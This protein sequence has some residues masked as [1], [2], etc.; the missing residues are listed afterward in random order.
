M[1]FVSSVN[2]FY[3][4]GIAPQDP[5]VS[6]CNNLNIDLTLRNLTETGYL[7]LCSLQP[8]PAP[9]RPGYFC[10]S[11]RRFF[12]FHAYFSVFS[13]LTT[14]AESR[15]GKISQHLKQLTLQVI[16]KPEITSRHQMRLPLSLTYSSGYSSTGKKS[17]RFQAVSVSLT[18]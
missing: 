14:S 3:Q 7:E 6:S 4:G 12:S 15:F 11:L 5:H 2:F 8:N 16:S 13:F 17:G 18:L 1:K 10:F 9:L